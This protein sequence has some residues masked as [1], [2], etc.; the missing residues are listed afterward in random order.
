M[1]RTKKLLHTYYSV[2]ETNLVTSHSLLNHKLIVNHGRLIP[3]SCR[4]I[5]AQALILVI[6]L[7]TLLNCCHQRV[8]AIAEPFLVDDLNP[9]SS[10]HGSSE[11][12]RV[13]YLRLHH[14][15]AH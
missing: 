5:V 14:M 12:L 1:D 8:M 2:V 10:P 15:E 13:K 7:L 3:G 6:L 4:S 11:S 9:P